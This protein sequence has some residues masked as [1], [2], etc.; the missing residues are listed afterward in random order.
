MEHDEVS[1]HLVEG[2]FET[3]HR[4]CNDLSTSAPGNY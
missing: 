2:Q 1:H 3:P 4:R